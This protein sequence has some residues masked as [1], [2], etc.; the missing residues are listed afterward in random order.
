MINLEQFK[1][2]AVKEVEEEKKMIADMQKHLEREDLT[3]EEKEVCKSVI[4]GATKALEILTNYLENSTRYVSAWQEMDNGGICYM[5]G[6]HGE[7][8]PLLRF[9]D[10]G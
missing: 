6:N 8:E 3:S 10:W 5:I 9:V 4:K 2:R 1:A 7:K